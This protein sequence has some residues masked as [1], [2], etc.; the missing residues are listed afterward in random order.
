MKNNIIQVKLSQN[1]YLKFQLFV[2]SQDDSIIKKRKK[3][4]LSVSIVYACLAIL[5]FLTTSTLFIEF[6]FLIIAILWYLLYPKYSKYR[7]E[8]HYK[9][10]IANHYQNRVDK[11]SEMQINGNVIFSKGLTGQSE[12]FINSVESI[13]EIDTHYF[14]K[15]E[16]GESFI[17]P[18][19]LDQ[20]NNDIYGFI[21]RLEELTKL[22]IIKKLNWKWN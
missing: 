1:D 10:H 8:K 7:Y 5:L 19:A 13:I 9:N 3:S 12:V 2:A 21:N 6:V 17:I 20:L 16:T 14:I 11:T 22:Q 15:I 4:R 18:K